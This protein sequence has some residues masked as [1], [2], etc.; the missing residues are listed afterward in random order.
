MTDRVTLYVGSLLSFFFFRKKKQRL[1]RIV[2]VTFYLVMMQTVALSQIVANR[3]NNSYHLQPTTFHL[4]SLNWVLSVAMDFLLALST[5]VD[6]TNTNPQECG[7]SVYTH[8]VLLEI[9]VNLRAKLR[10]RKA[11]RQRTDRKINT[12]E[13]YTHGEFSREI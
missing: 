5:C 10:K 11:Y 8:A 13:S 9:V 2:F 7:Q 1:E 3:D 6:N 4:C 12:F